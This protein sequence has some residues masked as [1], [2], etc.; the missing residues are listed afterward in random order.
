MASTTT[1]TVTG[2]P[3]VFIPLPTAWPS[4]TNCESNIYYAQIPNTYLAWDPIYGRDIVSS[5]QSCLPPQ[6]T[7]WWNQ[8]TAADPI[9]ALGP[10]FQCPEAYT[11]MQTAIIASSILQTFCCPSWVGLSFFV[12]L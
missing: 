8:A 5:A 1:L 6:V 2:T 7:N 11:P 10:T 12:K 4:K 3:T 9:I